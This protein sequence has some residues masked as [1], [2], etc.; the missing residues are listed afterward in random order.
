MTKKKG[1]RPKRV[2]QRICIACRESVEKRSL[3]RLVRTEDGIKVDL[4]SKMAGRG[5]YICSQ[6]SCW[7]NAL[8]SNRIAQAL[9][10]RISES[11]KE[12]LTKFMNSLMVEHNE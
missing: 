9:R 4:S 1:V 5:A 7:Q 11:N 2:P 6:I 8:N 3:V 12:E 10:T